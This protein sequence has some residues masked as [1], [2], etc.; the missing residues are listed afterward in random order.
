MTAIEE[1]ARSIFL[2]AVEHGADQWP[3]FLEEACGGNAELRV[4]VDQLLHAHQE[5]GSIHGG[6]AEAPGT[7]IDQPHTE[8]PGSVIG[9]YKLLEQIGEGGFGAVFMAE[10]VQPVR[11]KVAL[12]VL[13]PGMDTRQVVA[14]FEAERQALAI[15]DHPNIARVFDGGAAPSGRPYFVMELVKGVTITE[16]CD[17]NHLTLRQRLDLFIPVCQAVQH[18]HQKGIIHRDLKPSNVL[19]T[20]H[21]TTSVVKVIDFGVAKALGQ[22]LT[23]KTLFTGFAQ[24]IGTPLYMSPE[25]AG[26]S[27]LDIDTRSDIY[28]LGVLLYEL[29]TGSTP[30]SR[31]RFKRAAYDEMRR[32]I[33]EEE[34]PKPSTRLS[35]SK[36]TLPSIS[37]SRNTEPAK[38]TKTVRGELDWIVMKCLEKDRNRRYESASGLGMD[39]KRYL[40]DEPVLAGPPSAVY[41]LRKFVRRNQRPVLAASLILLALIGGIIGTTWGL[42]R[43]RRAEQAEAERARSEETAKIHALAAAEAEK[44]A[45][46]QAEKRLGQ[47]KKGNEIITSIF[48]DLDIRKVGHSKEPL[49]AV[50]ADRLIGAAT[51]IEAEAIGDPLVVAGLQDRLGLSLLHLGRIQPAIGLFL[52]ARETRSSI[53]GRNNQ[54]TLNTMNNLGAAYS[55]AHEFD[56]AIPLEEE[57]LERMKATLGHDHPDTLQSMNNLA[58]NYDT[59]GLREKA[60]PLQERALELSQAKLGEDNAFTLTCMNNL[61]WLYREVDKLE[62]AVDLYERTLRLMKSKLGSDHP[63]TLTC[64]NNLASAYKAQKK[65]EKAV[66][67]WEEVVA[68]SKARLSLD[69]PDTLASMNSLASGYR[70]VDKLEDALR[71]WKEVLNLRTAKLGRNDPDTIASMNNLARGFEYAGKLD[72]A[73]PLFEEAVRAL[74]RRGFRDTIAGQ[75]V[76]NL[77]NCQEQLK[78]FD[79]AESWRS[80]W[81]AVLKERGGA[82]SLPYADE[83]AALGSNL[84]EQKRWADAESILHE[85]LS[86]GEKKA[87]D[88]WPTFATKSLF[89]ESLLGQDKFAAAELSL[90]DGYQG[91]KRTEASAPPQAKHAQLE[92]ALERLVRL[93]HAWGKPGQ[94]AAWA[95]NLEDERQNAKKR[96][97]PQ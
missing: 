74:E 71:L 80:K 58:V 36:D 77:I 55:H 72:T 53:L 39:L 61:A 44:L 18:A 83:L 27:A 48:T 17:Q 12:K 64:M 3:A 41:R 7:T 70:A 60:L 16:F 79:H 67:L 59:A 35:E 32:I 87:A 69:H 91:M 96:D 21:D 57:T 10:Q 37:A 40:N 47:I 92:A 33:R 85:S 30:I 65:F 52:K 75:I 38:L 81:L 4:R 28:S 84:L 78:Q 86:I 62:K 42:I 93:Y 20:M 2:A 22:E 19:V 26:Q 25:Q 9:A 14:R 46:E 82:D 97:K 23:D 6:G 15:M 5:M 50:L 88:A 63:D 31:D 95:Q 76:R 94:A 51:Q 90:L 11:R 89:G 73:L 66:A 68:L 45:K 24:M 43:A 8:H 1:Q 54:L 29:L 34:P 13:K 49:E 56:K